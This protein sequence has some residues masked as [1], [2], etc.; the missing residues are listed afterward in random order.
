MEVTAFLN[1]RVW[2]FNS[3]SVIEPD[4]ESFELA[5]EQV[6]DVEAGETTRE[7]ATKIRDAPCAETCLD[8]GLSVQLV[9]RPCSIA[10]APEL[11]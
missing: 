8:L 10:I 4:A 11:R 2:R 6:V 3:S 9:R 7:V 5:R 1:T